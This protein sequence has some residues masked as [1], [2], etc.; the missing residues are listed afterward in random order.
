M[1]TRVSTKWGDIFAPS[2]PCKDDY[3]NIESFQASGGQIVKLQL[4]AL[5]SFQECE[6]R[7]GE[8]TGRK[9]DRQIAL[10][11]SWRSCSYQSSLYAKDQHRYAPPNVTL[12]CRGLAIDVSQAQPNLEMI[13]EILL[14]H[15][16]R[17]ARPD[18]EPWHYSYHF[19][20]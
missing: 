20:A 5:H 17:Q 14:N 7:Y 12:H 3:R 15:G 2:G 18:D 4:G 6:R 11:G 9:G 16:W 8:R 1:P 19:V 10:T 13:R